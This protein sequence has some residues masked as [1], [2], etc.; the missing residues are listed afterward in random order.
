MSKEQPET[1]EGLVEERT[2]LKGTASQHEGVVLTTNDGEKLR[3]QRIGGNPFADAVTRRL[4]GR[5]VSLQGYRRGGVFRFIAV[6]TKE[7]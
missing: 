7:T 6:N 3:L 4:V 2:V 5:K 1:I